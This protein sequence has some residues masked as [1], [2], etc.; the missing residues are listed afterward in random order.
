M[1]KR[2]ITIQDKS[3]FVSRHSLCYFQLRLEDIILS[4]QMFNV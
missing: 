3:A 2:I 1:Q 4:T